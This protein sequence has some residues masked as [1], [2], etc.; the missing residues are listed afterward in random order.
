MIIGS[1]S[2]PKAAKA[3]QPFLN[4]PAHSG[5]KPNTETQKQAPNTQKQAPRK[6][7][8]LKARQ[9]ISGL[10]GRAKGKISVGVQ[11]GEDMERCDQATQTYS[12]GPTCD[13]A[14][15]VIPQKVMQFTKD[16]CSPSAITKAVARL[17][18]RMPESPILL[19]GKKE[20]M[21]STP[22]FNLPTRT[23][24]QDDLADDSVL[25]E[26]QDNTRNVPIMTKSPI[27]KKLNF[28]LDT[29]NDTT[30]RNETLDKTYAISNENRV[31]FT[32]TYSQ[33]SASIP[34]LTV[35]T[36]SRARLPPRHEITLP[37]SPVLLTD[38]KYSNK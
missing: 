19:T 29:E 9:P 15:Q 11:T 6:Y 36:P 24:S 34:K 12:G 17:D 5:T 38:I 16:D 31:P 22:V 13:Q 4:R 26:K 10:V 8:P 32:S 25:T 14:V 30:L 21:A 18:I 7:V 20:R 27:R 2:P 28:D 37:A 23:L 1:F 33:S 3:K 35:Q